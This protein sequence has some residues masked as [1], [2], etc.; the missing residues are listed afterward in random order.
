[1]V[2]KAF[3]KLSGMTRPEFLGVVLILFAVFAVAGLN[4]LTSEVKTRDVKRK[5]D[6]RYISDS[7]EVFFR[8]FEHYPKAADGII[9]G[10]GTGTNPL[11]CH[12]GQDRITRINDPDFSNTLP[13]DPLSSQGYRYVYFS[14]TQGFQI[15]AHLER[16]QNDE[17]NENIEKRGIM[18]GTKVCNFGLASGGTRLD[19]DLP[20]LPATGSALPAQ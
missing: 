17:Y 20:E 4:F 16:K 15:F 7:V 19:Q 8:D 12:W 3:V 9:L 14:N 13:D 18:C 6:V 1:M 2:H 5:V 10:C 11:P